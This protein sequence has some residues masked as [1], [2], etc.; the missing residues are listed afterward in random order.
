MHEIE[1][2]DQTQQSPKHRT[3]DAL[4]I[5]CRACREYPA[6][7][8][9]FLDTLLEGPDPAWAGLALQRLQFEG[10]GNDA[11]DRLRPLLRSSDSVVGA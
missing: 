6:V 5:L 4:R 9:R 11:R 1:N 7:L 3:Y 2:E 8:A 10:A